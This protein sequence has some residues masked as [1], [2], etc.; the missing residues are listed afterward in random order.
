MKTV[1]LSAIALSL[2]SAGTAFASEDH[3][4]MAACKAECPTAKTE[5]EAHA[6]MKEVVKKKKGDKK[7]RKSDC[8]EALREHEK[9][10]K[11]SG[12]SH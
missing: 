7:F 11:E 1:I 8:F 12:H 10:E 9:H 2:A 3:N 4:L 5:H 6:C